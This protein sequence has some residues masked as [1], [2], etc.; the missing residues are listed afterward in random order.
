MRTLRRALPRV[1]LWKWLIVV[2]ALASAAYLGLHP[3]RRWL[4]LLGG[5]MV[6]VALLA[7]PV[8]GLFALMVAALVIPMRISTG[9][10]VYLNPATLMV[11]ALLLLWLVTML[12]RGRL[13]VAPSRV[14]APLLYFVL[15]GGVSLLVGNALWDPAIPRPDNM[16]AVQL[17]QWAIFAFSAGAFWLAGNLVQDDVWLQRLTFAFLLLGGV[18]ALGRM[19][20]F[21]SPWTRIATAAT[22]RAPFWLLF[23]A[24]AGGQVLFNHQL[25]DGVK[26]LLLALLGGIVFYAFVI[27][28]ESASTWVAV[29]A[30]VGVLIWLRWPR[31][32]WPIVV[33]LIALTASGLLFSTA[34]RFAGGQSEWLRTG[35]SRIALIRRVVQ[36]TMRNPVTGLGPASYRPYANMEPLAHRKAFWINPKISS[37][38]NYV[39]L[40]AHIGL[41]GL[42]LFFWF[43]GEI[44]NLGLSLQKRFPNGFLS[45]YVNGMLA[46]GAASLIVMLIADWILPFVYNISFQG[47][48]ASVLVWMFLGGLVTLDRMPSN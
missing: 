25:A 46:A 43:V 7:R 9:T 12:L 44:T 11:P 48:Q 41:V 2:G 35:S 47:F 24:L 33:L 28:R 42:G 32:R 6:A 14:N 10:Q 15:A 26:M 40:F 4:V 8:L 21:L 23:T 16:L 18:L 22:I 17:A 19:I 3:S 45:G 1:D 29:G 27:M 13:E 34:W 37:H 30:V 39:D 31:L 38:N 36:V 5:G 20:P